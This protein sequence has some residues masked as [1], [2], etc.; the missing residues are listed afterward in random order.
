LTTTT[1]TTQ[2]LT[3]RPLIAPDD[4]RYGG[5]TIPHAGPE[6][7]PS[8]ES[9]E[10]YGAQ[11]WKAPSGHWYLI[12]GGSSDVARIRVWGQIDQRAKGNTFIFRGPKSRTA[13][14][15]VVTAVDKHGVPADLP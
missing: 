7:P 8:G 10:T 1:G 13:P 5:T 12:V 6:H 11:W 9:Y 4:S 14:S 3:E 2:K 15:T